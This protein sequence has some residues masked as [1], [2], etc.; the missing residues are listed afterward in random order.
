M[1]TIKSNP[2]Y[3]NPHKDIWQEEYDN[4]DPQVRDVVTNEPY[5]REARM[6]NLKV[7]RLIERKL[8]STVE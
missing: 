2:D 6:L 4:L 8:L 5:S 1:H 7:D 3:W